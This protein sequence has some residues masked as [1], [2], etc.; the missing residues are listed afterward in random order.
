MIF[1]CEC[2][3]SPLAEV[4]SFGPMRIRLCPACKIRLEQLWRLPKKVAA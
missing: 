1:A 4:V 2:C 3:F